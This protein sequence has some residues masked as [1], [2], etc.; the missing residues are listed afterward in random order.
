MT[1]SIGTFLACVLILSNVLGKSN[2]RSMNCQKSERG[3]LDFFFLLVRDCMV[4]YYGGGGGYKTGGR[5]GGVKFYP[6]IRGG[7]WGRSFSHA[8]GGTH[9]VSG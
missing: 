6:Y 2:N 8:E 1:D 3:N 5:G 9:K 7:G 4:T